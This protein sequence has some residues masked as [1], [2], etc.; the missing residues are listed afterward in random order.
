[1]TKQ[2]FIDQVQ[3]AAGTDLTKADTASI[4]EAVFDRIGEVVKTEESFRWNGFGTFETRERPARNGRNP[5]TG[6]P[7]KIAASTSVAFRPASALKELV[8]KNGQAKSKK[9]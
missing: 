5:Q 9:K 8:G 4:V 3:E 1:M 6:K 7:L 2:E